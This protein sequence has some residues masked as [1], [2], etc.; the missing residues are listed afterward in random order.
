VTRLPK[1]IVASILAR[2]RKVAQEAAGNAENPARHLRCTAKIVGIAPN[3]HEHVVDD[4]LDI[5]AALRESQQE[6]GEPLLIAEI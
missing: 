3:H 2:L 4:L 1:N 6:T 5:L